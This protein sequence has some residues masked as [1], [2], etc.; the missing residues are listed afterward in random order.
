MRRYYTQRLEGA[1]G[2]SD[3]KNLYWKATWE[4]PSYLS[5]DF[6]DLW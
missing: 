2:E 1:K 6:H 5:Y 4:V 3:Y